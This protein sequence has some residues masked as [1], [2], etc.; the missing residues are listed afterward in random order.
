MYP[1]GHRPY[2]LSNASSWQ[3]VGWLRG[4]QFIDLKRQ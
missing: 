2:G 3:D 4:S 1:D